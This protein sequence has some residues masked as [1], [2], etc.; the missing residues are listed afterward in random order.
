MIRLIERARVSDSD[1]LDNSDS[2]TVHV[3]ADNQVIEEKIILEE[4]LK[5]NTAAK[6]NSVSQSVALLKGR[7]ATLDCKKISTIDVEDITVF[8]AKV[9][10]SEF[11]HTKNPIY[12]TL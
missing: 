6:D 2:L 3:F 8:L 5:K 4:I 10:F 9:E 1:L 7:C 12:L 11:N